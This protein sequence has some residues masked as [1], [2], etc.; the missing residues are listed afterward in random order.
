MNVDEFNKGNPSPIQLAPGQKA[1][2]QTYNVRRTVVESSK[3]LAVGKTNSDAIPDP[4]YISG[5]NVFTEVKEILA[6]A[7]SGDTFNVLTIPPTELGAPASTHIRLAG[8]EQNGTPLHLKL[9][10]Q[11]G[12]GLTLAMTSGVGEEIQYHISGA[13]I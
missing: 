6:Y 1:D 12:W 5:E 13:E 4:I 8:V 11:P 2:L 9:S 7:A 10:L 3:T